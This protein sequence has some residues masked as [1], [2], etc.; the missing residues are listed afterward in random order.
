MRS[1]EQQPTL[2][3]D[4]FSSAGGG[5]EL[6][7]VLAAGASAVE[8]RKQQKKVLKMLRLLCFFRLPLDWDAGRTTGEGEGEHVEMQINVP[9]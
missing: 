5:G 3:G 1:V 2:G 7:L 4:P 6:V 9:S 8:S